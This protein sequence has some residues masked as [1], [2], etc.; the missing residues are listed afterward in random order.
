MG[1]AGPCW[2]QHQNGVIAPLRPAVDHLGR[3]LIGG[4]DEK[5]LHAKR[6]ALAQIEDELV[7]RRPHA[8]ALACNEA[9]RNAAMPCP[10]PARPVV[11]PGQWRATPIRAGGPCRF[12][13]PSYA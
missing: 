11:V 10:M 5:V 8:L 6:G 3:P 4:A 2:R 12:R 1:L 7:G 9:G 13:S